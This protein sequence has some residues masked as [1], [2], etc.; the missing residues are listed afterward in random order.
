MKDEVTRNFIITD[1]GRKNG[2]TSDSI[3]REASHIVCAS[4]YDYFGQ[5]D[6]YASSY[7]KNN[8]LVGVSITAEN[9]VIDNFIDHHIE[10]GYLIEDKS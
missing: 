1:K 9:I 6:I 5:V 7:F 10:Y 4:Q 2:I 8:C 3:A